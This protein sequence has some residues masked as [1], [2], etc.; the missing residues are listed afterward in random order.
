MASDLLPNA[1]KQVISSF[2]LMEISG[3]ALPRRSL[4]HSHSS[5]KFEM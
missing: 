2:G 3:I 5:S 1:S 4:E